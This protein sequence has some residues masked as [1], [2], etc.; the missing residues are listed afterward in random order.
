MKTIRS[1]NVALMF[2]TACVTVTMVGCSSS[3]VVTA[4]QTLPLEQVTVASDEKGVVM[5]IRT[6]P[7]PQA[8]NWYDRT[9][10][11][12]AQGKSPGVE[13]KLENDVV[14][15]EVRS[16]KD[17]KA[18]PTDVTAVFIDSPLKAIDFMDETRAEVGVA[19]GG[20]LDD[21]ELAG[22]PKELIGNRP[23]SQA[24]GLS[25]FTF[26]PGLAEGIQV[27]SWTTPKGEP[28]VRSGL[29]EETV[30]FPM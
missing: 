3:P 4:V 23:V 8:K 6:K 11:N 9:V 16:G 28:R 1:Q 2:A 15:V 22:I 10:A 14:I 24:S 13:I 18:K 7:E 19:L 12:L 26:G 25:A 21:K 29:R 30:I 20:T 27:T 17:P 5:R